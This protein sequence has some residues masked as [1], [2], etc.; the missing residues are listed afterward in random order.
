MS[1]GLKPVVLLGA[2]RSGTKI[3]RDAL[4]V[5]TGVPAV[6]YDIGYVWRYGNESVDHDC[7]QPEDIRPRTRRLVQSYLSRYADADGRLIEKTV[8]NTL[9]V[10]FVADLMPNA[11]YVHLV[12]DGVDVAESTRRQWQEPADIDYLRDKVRH[13]PARMVPTYGRKYALSVIRQRLSKDHR[14]ATWGPRYRGID[15]DLQTADLLTVAAR[16]WRESLSSASTDLHALDLPMIE[17]RYEDLV[18]APAKTLR[19][20]AAF[21]GSE[22]DDAAIERAS[23]T[24]RTGRAGAGALA[25][26]ERE[27]MRLDGEI[28]DFLVHWGYSR[29]STRTSDR[30]R[31][32]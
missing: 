11:V 10:G 18:S 24:V 26:S 5:A 16:Q 19:Q 21:A 6:P 2:A 1:F 32:E 7:L 29:A 31:D 30:H 9:R 4:S 22:P 17:V 3:M 23:A 20:V 12:R 8:G 15:A 28:G 14:V 25:L 13:F 27:L